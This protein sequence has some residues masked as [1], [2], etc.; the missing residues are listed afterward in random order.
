MKNADWLDVVA[1]SDSILTRFR[2]DLELGAANQHPRLRLHTQEIKDDRRQ[3]ARLSKIA[4]IQD[5]KIKD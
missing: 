1:R 5:L 4:H 3:L 2:G